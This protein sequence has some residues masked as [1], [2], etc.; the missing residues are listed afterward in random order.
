M[1]FYLL[2]RNF[3][4]FICRNAP[5]AKTCHGNGTVYDDPFPMQDSEGVMLGIKPHPPPVFS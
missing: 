3:R 5:A 2:Y 1:L 4:Q